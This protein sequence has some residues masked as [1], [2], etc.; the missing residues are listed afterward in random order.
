MIKRILAFVFILCGV[1]GYSQQNVEFK[2]ENFKDKKDQLKEAVRNLEEGDPHFQEGMNF[3]KK[4][5]KGEDQAEGYVGAYVSMALPFYLKAQDFNPNNALLNYKIGF[6]YLYSPFKWKALPFFENAVKLNPQ[7][8]P[9]INYYIARG[10]HL[11]KHWDDAINYYKKAAQYF[12]PKDDRWRIEDC[13]KKIKECGYGKDYEKNPTRVFIDNVGPEVN[14][15]YPDYGPVIS[16]DESIMFLTSRRPGSTG[17]QQSEGSNYFEDIYISKNMGGKWLIAVN[18][19]KPINT[20]GHDATVGLS[21]DGQTLLIYLDDGGDGNIYACEQKGEFWNKPDKVSSNVNTKSHE[22]SASLSAD[23]TTLY[24]VTNKEGGIGLHDIYYVK[25]DEKGKWGKPVNLGPVIN[26]KYNEESVFIHPDGKT[27]YFSSEGHTSSGG[28][29]IFKS[30]YNEKTLQWSAPE[31]LGYPVNSPDDDIDFV[32]S[33]SGKHGYYS[34]FKMD[35]YGE[36]DIYMIT[37]LGAEK[38]PLLNNE[39]NLLA[40]TA[41]PVKEQVSMQKVEILTAQLTILKGTITD[42]FTKKP[43]DAD[44][45]LV[46]NQLGKVIATFKSNSATGKYLVSLPAGKNYGIAVKKDGY[47]F[48]SENFDIPM[49]AS[50]QDVVKDIELKNVKVGTKIVLRN[51]FFDFDKATL[52]PESKTELDRLIQLL[53][54]IPT[55]KIEISG[56]TDSKGSDEYNLTLSKNRAQAVVDYL[57]KA[58]ISSG[59]LV[60]AGYGETRPIDTNDTDDGR[61]N[62]RR[63][64]FEILSK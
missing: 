29:D 43:L 51:I 19:G 22:S 47:L 38:P 9:D 3:L 46:D 60:S 21:A 52:R 42:A 13:E 12:D 39:D 58:G 31:N 27:L 15:A 41:A 6:C 14:S 26:T 45:E 53:N 59:R 32:L 64:E 28:Y 44:I 18:A 36:K 34:S 37:F 50:Y 5:Y 24:F 8:V 54:D 16:A 4:Y 57:I 56:H 2:K 35:G 40:S 49:T 17:G 62:N 55:L 20:E 1:L 48:H 11:Q 61:Q 7:V 30:I 10:H 23:G 25:K 33:A 63:T